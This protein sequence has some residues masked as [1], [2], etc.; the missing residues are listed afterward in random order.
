M[1]TP[2]RILDTLSFP[3]QYLDVGEALTR[4]LGR[5]VGDYYRYCGVPCP[6]AAQPGDTLTGSQIR[7]TNEWMLSICPPGIPPL[8]SFIR[9]FPVTSHGPIGMLAIT[10][11]TLGEALD[12]ALNFFPLVMPAYRLQRHDLRDRMHLVFEPLYDF[13]PV[14]AFFTETV[15]T[16]FLQIAPF[17][18]RQPSPMPEIHLRQEALGPVEAYESAFNCRF[19][20]GSTQNQLVLG[21]EALTIPLLAPSPSS[22]QL[23]R[24]ALEQQS[25]QQADARPVTQA[26]RRYLREALRQGGLPDAAALAAQ[27]AMSARTLSRRL[28][29]EGSTLP[30]LRAEVG[31]DHAATLLLETDKSIAQIAV[32]S[33]FQDAA[34]FT[35]AFRRCRGV[36][37]TALRAGA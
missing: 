25:R 13:G 31:C 18:A 20:F 21:R 2:D 3:A 4:A 26:V 27:L 22:H 11:R 7:R 37:P 32:A 14:S 24:A 12:G 29:D 15:V 16:A 17:L 5:E 6:R 28:Q 35:R 8:V 33:G 34:A 9:H 1:T 30:R 19:V 36:T 10:A 23:M